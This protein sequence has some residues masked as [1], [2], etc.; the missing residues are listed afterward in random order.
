MPAH[1][2]EP[3]VDDVLGRASIAGAG[4]ADAD[5]RAEHGRLTDR[6]AILE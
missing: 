2:R 1:H 5:P 4:R 3:R 6:K